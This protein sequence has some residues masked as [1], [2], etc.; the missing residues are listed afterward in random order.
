[1]VFGF[2]WI[3]VYTLN[4]CVSHTGRSQ[5]VPFLPL[6]VGGGIFI[7]LMEMTLAKLTKNDVLSVGIQ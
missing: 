6:G 3:Q 4:A 7:K 2:N 5:Q 1:M